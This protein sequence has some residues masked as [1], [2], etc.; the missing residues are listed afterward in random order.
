[1]LSRCASKTKQREIV[2]VQS[3]SRRHLPN[4]V[5]HRFDAYLEKGRRKRLRCRLSSGR[6]SNAARKGRE[7]GRNNPDVDSRPTV[8][9]EYSRQ[10]IWP[11]P[12]QQNLYVGKGERPPTPVARGS[13][14][15]PGRRRP[16]GKPPIRKANYRSPARGDRVHVE[17]RLLESHASDDVLKTSR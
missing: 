10:R 14:I 6:L 8:A 4:S 5:G 1:V 17:H 15:R 11:Q 9:S 13:R 2:S 12:T 7:L 16:Y 3:L